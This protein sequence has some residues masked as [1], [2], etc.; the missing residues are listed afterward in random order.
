MIFVDTSAWYALYSR[1]DANHSAAAIAVRSF[2]DPL[3]TSDYVVDET[4]T[5][6]RARGENARAIAFGR[7]MMAGRTVR[8]LRIEDQ[9]FA[10]A[11]NIFHGFQDKEWSFTDCTSRVVMQRL[12]IQYAFTF[13]DHFRQFGIVTILP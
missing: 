8:V 5:L 13:D 11:W 2:Q 3:V 12:G 6:L 4:L 9:D 10:D 1:R 7:R